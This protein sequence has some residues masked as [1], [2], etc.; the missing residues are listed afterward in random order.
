MKLVYSA[1]DERRSGAMY[2]CP[3]ACQRL[4]QPKYDFSERIAL[5]GPLPVARGVP[6]GAAVKELFCA[7]ED[8]AFRCKAMQGPGSSE[9]AQVWISTRRV[10]TARRQRVVLIR[11]RAKSAEHFCSHR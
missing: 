9:A 1:S 7:V 6:Q 8:V 10:A 5:A 2:S 11:L 3:D 4:R